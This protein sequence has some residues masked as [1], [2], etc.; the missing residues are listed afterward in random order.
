MDED[1]F[2]KICTYLHSIEQG[3]WNIASE[4]GSISSKLNVQYDNYANENLDKLQEIIELL[5]KSKL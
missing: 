2:E 3:I 5:Q 4:V 1:Q